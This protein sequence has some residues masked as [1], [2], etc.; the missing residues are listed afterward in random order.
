MK[1]LSLKILCVT[2][3]ISFVGVN[4]QTKHSELRNIIRLN[5]K[6]GLISAIYNADIYVEGISPEIKV[7]NYLSNNYKLFGMKKDISDLT[8]TN[9]RENLSTKH[10]VL[11]HFYEGIEVINS[12]IVISLNKENKISMVVSNYHPISKLEIYPTIERNNAESKVKMLFQFNNS[13]NDLVTKSTLRIFV[14]ENENS[15]LI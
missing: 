2:F 4:S 12:S 7:K 11:K 8:I 13:H 14:D 15:Y 10:V 3:L 9:V 1:K 6:T 5:E